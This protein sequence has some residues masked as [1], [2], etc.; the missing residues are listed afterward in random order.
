M[1]SLRC[2]DTWSPH[3]IA[4]FESAI[5]LYGKLFAKIQKI[6]RDAVFG[7]ALAVRFMR[8]LHAATDTHE[9][10]AGHRGVLL[11]VEEIEELCCVEA[12]LQTDAQPHNLTKYSVYT[13][14]KCI[15]EQRIHHCHRHPVR[16][17]HNC[18]QQ[19][20]VDAFVDGFVVAVKSRATEAARKHATGCQTL[21]SCGEQ[22]PHIQQH[23]HRAL[24][25]SLSTK[26]YH[27]LVSASHHQAAE[28][29]Q[30]Q[31]EKPRHTS[32]AASI[33]AQAQLWT[34][35][36]HPHAQQ[37]HKHSCYHHQHGRSPQDRHRRQMT[38]RRTQSRS[39]RT[40]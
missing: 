19:T 30:G 17:A 33:S 14:P 6:V 21:A 38:D 5:C 20:S 31:P 27:H 7:H 4:L 8:C 39:Q 2:A 35:H 24:K 34:E 18:E 15:R 13:N 10:N 25:S 26:R 12:V 16:Q 23:T 29:Q 22:Q 32:D 9:A 36:V 28:I 40:G 11:C 37:Q 3:E 1:L